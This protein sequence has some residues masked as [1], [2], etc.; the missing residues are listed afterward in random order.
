MPIRRF[1][2][3]ILFGDIYRKLKKKQLTTLPKLARDTI[4]HF[5]YYNKKKEYIICLDNARFLNH[6]KN[7]NLDE[8]NPTKTVAKRDIHPG[9]ELTVNYYEYDAD[10]KRKLTNS[11][12]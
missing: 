11:L 9:E 8:T 5:C 4:F 2:K 6:S 10:A 7:P 3:E 12:R 1:R